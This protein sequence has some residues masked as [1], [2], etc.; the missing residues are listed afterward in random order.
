[1]RSRLGRNEPPVSDLGVPDETEYADDVNF[2]DEDMEKLKAMLPHIKEILGE[3]N[4]FVNDT[5]TEYTR[6][7]LAGVK[8]VNTYGK[9]IRECL[10]LEDW[11][12]TKLLGSLL[13]SVQDILRRCQLG[14]AAFESYNKCWLKGSNIPLQI[15]IRL[16]DSLVASVMLYNCNS[17]AVP[18]KDLE[19]LDTTHRRH[20]RRMLNMYWPRGKIRKVEL[21]KRCDTIKLSERV[22]KMRWTMLG[23]ILRSDEQTPAFPS[24]KFALNN[25]LK[26]RRGKHQSNLFK[27]VLSDL[28]ARNFHLLDL[29]DFMYLRELAFDRA[30]WRSCTSGGDLLVP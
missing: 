13:C 15:K 26:G 25:K 8:E 24:F 11:R 27:T 12:S 3:W 5:K 1:M 14:N 7:H 4:L 9:K 18:D 23:H 22:K 6:V 16:Y 30:H 21:Y 28:E 29:D 17:W 19:K 2:L 20:L 10:K